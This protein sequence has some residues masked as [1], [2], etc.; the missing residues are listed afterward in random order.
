[1][2]GKVNSCHFEMYHWIYLRQF[3]LLFAFFAKEE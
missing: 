1:M 3:D 2:R